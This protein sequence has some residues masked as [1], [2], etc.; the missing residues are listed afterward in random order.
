MKYWIG[1]A[2]MAVGFPV[3][4]LSLGI[5]SIIYSMMGFFTGLV[6]FF[7]GLGIFASDFADRFIDA[8]GGSK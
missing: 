7:V 6:V 4:I 8:I 1:I 5:V 2:L 3:F